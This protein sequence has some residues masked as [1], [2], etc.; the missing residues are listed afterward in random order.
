MNQILIIGIYFDIYE[1][2]FGELHP[3]RLKNP[4][5]EKFS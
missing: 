4:L 2:S 1:A 3:K 5:K